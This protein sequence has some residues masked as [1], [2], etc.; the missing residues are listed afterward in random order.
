MHQTAFKF[1][2]KKVAKTNVKLF[3]EL[4]DLMLYAARNKTTVK[5]VFIGKASPKLVRE[6]E[7]H[8]LDFKDAKVYVDSSALQHSFKKHGVNS[9]MAK[10]GALPLCPFDLMFLPDL[11]QTGRIIEVNKNGFLIEKTNTGVIGG[12]FCTMRVSNRKGKRIFLVS[13]YNSKKKGS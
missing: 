3:I 11:I 6:G 8:G 12:I 9:I 1:K 13:M 4:G 2:N 7:K 5:R 10:N